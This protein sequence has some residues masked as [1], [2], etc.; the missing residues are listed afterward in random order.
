MLAPNPL[1]QEIA[2]LRDELAW[3][4][5]EVRQLKD[6]FT[7][8]LAFPQSWRLSPDETQILA[9]L[10]AATGSGVL[11]KEALHIAIGDLQV[12]THEKIVDI[13][14]H[15]IRRKVKPYGVMIETVWGVGYRMPPEARRICRRA[16]DGAALDGGGGK[17]AAVAIDIHIPAATEEPTMHESNAD[18]ITTLIAIARQQPAE[19]AGVL[20]DAAI[21]LI[22][23]ERAALA[24]GAGAEK[25]PRKARAAKPPLMIEDN[26]RARAERHKGSATG[27]AGKVTVADNVITF[28]G[29]ITVPQREADLA[30]EL[31]KVMPQMLGREDLAVKIWGKADASKVAMVSQLSI[32]LHKSVEAIGLK[33][34]TL[35]GIG[36][37]L[38]EK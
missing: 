24:N 26:S 34:T 20:F 10:M 11:S 31:V 12:E 25:A 1:H 9:A 15:R 13:H 4:T 29:S 21:A 37:A 27:P 3:R 17:T 35:R 14:I 23:S 36:V 32:A 5:E 18:P 22:Q 33:V 2:A 30:T 19:R 28:K 16:L 38:Q 8:V 7:P 6:V